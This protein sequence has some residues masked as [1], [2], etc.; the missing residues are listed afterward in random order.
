MYTVQGSTVYKIQYIAGLW[1]HV[2]LHVAEFDI[3]F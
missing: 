2:K 1:I 3:S